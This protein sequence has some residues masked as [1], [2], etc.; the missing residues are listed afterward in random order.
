MSEVFADFVGVTFLVGE[1]PEVR[2]QIQPALDVVSA[3]CEHDEGDNG[4]LWRA[5]DGTV[6]AK[7]YGPVMML[8]ASGA[9]L[10]GLRLA[11]MLGQYLDAVASR[12]HT[13]TRLD[14]SLDVREPTAPVI[15][16]IVERVS[17]PEGLSLTR[18]RV[19]SQHV[20][21]LVTRGDD[22][23][24]TGTVY[25]GSRAA[26]VRLCVY[27]KRM[28]RMARKLPDVGPLTRYE[29]R[30]KSHVGLT[31]RDVWSPSSVFWHFVA[32]DV[33]PRPDGVPAWQPH[34]E[35]FAI[36][37][38]DVPLPA[39]RLVALVQRS[40]EAR[41]LAQLAHEV[42]PYGFSLLLSELQR[43]VPAGH[44]DR[45]PAQVVGSQVVGA[46]SAILGPGS[47]LPC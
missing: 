46:P 32:P 44:G 9:I 2:E 21:R 6:K 3:S 17:S 37:R 13:V 4:A 43:L 8:G 38:R 25:V 7:R 23:Q 18:K 27:D 26:E 39:Q 42:G 35:P 28:E 20:T 31:L 33:L 15:A 11:G 36:P 19:S 45:E 14:A 34:G 16:R 40:P 12:P 29:L 1:W 22:G 30:L 41:R 47:A 5:G 24:D 10:A